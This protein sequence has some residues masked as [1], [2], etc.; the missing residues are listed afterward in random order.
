MQHKQSAEAMQPLPFTGVPTNTVNETSSR[1]KLNTKKTRVN[2]E[3]AF[4]LCVFSEA[5]LSMTNGIPVSLSKD[6]KTTKTIDRK[7][8]HLC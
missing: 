8:T 5:S 1:W 2:M 4:V 7:Q 3:S 6:N